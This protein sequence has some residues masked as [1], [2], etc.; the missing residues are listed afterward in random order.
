[1]SSLETVS[2]DLLHPLVAAAIVAHGLAAEAVRCDPALADTAAFCDAYGVD[3]HDSANTLIVIGKA[4]ESAPLAACLV[5]ATSRL[6]V[7][8][9]VK[10][11]LGTRK[12]SFAAQQSACEVTGMEYGGVTVVGLP[13]DMPLW[14][15]TAVLA[16]SQVIVGGGNRS[17]KLVLSPQELLKLPNAEAVH[18]LSKTAET[19]A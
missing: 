4:A 2:F 3:P 16:R 9:T 12:A 13:S 17:S 14:I 19:S 18:G 11:R 1:V 10:Q 15:D 5:L 7:N 8:G 6:D